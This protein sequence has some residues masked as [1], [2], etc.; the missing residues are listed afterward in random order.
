MAAIAATGDT[1]QASTVAVLGGT[2]TLALLVIVVPAVNGAEGSAAGFAVLTVCCLPVSWLLRTLPDAPEPEHE[3]EHVKATQ[4]P[5]SV[6]FLLALVMLGATDQG[7]WSYSAV[8]GEDYA[9]MSSSAVSSVLAIASIVS[10][11]GVVLSRPATGRF[12]RFATFTTFIAV[13]CVAKLAIAAVPDGGVFTAA[14]IVW[15]ICYMGVLVS[16]LAVA[17]AADV[18]GRWV[19]ASSGALAIGAGLVL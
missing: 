10:L 19:A 18:S 4:T 15:Q 17:A 13:E 16:M 7:A 3:H 9:S 14:A 6:F 11:A 1:D 5:L 8:L 2:I 12:G